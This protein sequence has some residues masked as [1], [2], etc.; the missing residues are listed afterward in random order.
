MKKNVTYPPQLKGK[1]T[2]YHFSAGAQQAAHERAALHQRTSR[3]AVPD[4]AFENFRTWLLK[5]LELSDMFIFF[6]L[7]VGFMT[8]LYVAVRH[9]ELF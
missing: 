5:K 9:P 2:D 6:L 7:V 4:T 3:E 1:I 8:T